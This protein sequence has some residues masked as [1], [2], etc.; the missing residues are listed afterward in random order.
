MPRP[1]RPAL[2][3]LLLV[4]GLGATGVTASPALAESAPPSTGPVIDTGAWSQQT[5]P[6]LGYTVLLPPGFERVTDD[7]A[8]PVPSF[9]SIVDRDAQTGT[10]LSAAAQRIA[11]NGGLF[12]GLGLWSVDP[13]S[14]LQLGVL[15]GQPYR[16]GAAELRTIVEQTVSERASDMA[17]PVVQAISVPA[18]SGYLAVYLDAT[19]LAQHQEI[20][21]RTPTGRY[22]IVATSYPGFADP[23]LE[24]TVRA[25]AGSLRAIPASAAD[26]PDP[27]IPADGDADPALQGM[28]PDHLAGMTLTRKSLAGESLVSSS[29]TVTGSIAGELG[30]LVPAPG[31]VTLALAVPADGAAPLLIAAY[32][33][34]GIT[35][36]AVQAFVDS[37]PNDIWSDARV[38]GHDVRVSIVGDSGNR[39]WLR[40]AA[41][42]G[43]DAVLYQVDA[44]KPSLGMAAIA[45]LP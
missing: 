44:G 2:A 29:D 5:M 21:L 3:S 8:A 15:A 40:V 1:I 18:G 32:R 12:D 43:G 10:A 33:L 30:R 45:A 26:L 17:E 27:G 34:H 39:T 38:A 24:A 11:D 20:H 9:A 42:P 6:F 36:A 13:A 41:G 19:D 35:T 28:L 7:P 16:V 31:D 14:L 23:T 25:I 37:F 22:L 4:V